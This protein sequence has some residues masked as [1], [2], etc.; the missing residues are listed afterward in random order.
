MNW[1]KNLNSNT[2][3]G[4]IHGFF[5]VGFYIEFDFQR[6]REES[7][8]IFG[9]QKGGGV[10]LKMC[11]FYPVLEVPTLWIRQWVSSIL[12]NSWILYNQLV[13]SQGEMKKETKKKKK[14]KN[15]H[16]KTQ[17]HIELF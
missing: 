3:Q 9:F 15:T 1:T 7:T 14:K 17:T 2:S 16:K 6:G 11:Y 5:K 4:R 10:T 12:Y 8:I 13:Y